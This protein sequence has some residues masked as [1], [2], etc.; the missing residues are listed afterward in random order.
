MDNLTER[1][2]SVLE[3]LK[4]AKSQGKRL[5]MKGVI[6]RMAA[7]GVVI[8]TH[9]AAYD[10]GKLA[11]TKGSGVYSVRF[12]GQKTLWGYDPRT[13]DVEVDKND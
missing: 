9:Q 2:L 5:Y 12:G 4:D 11:Y 7:K 3:C 1:Q 10:L 8:S 6:N 13:S